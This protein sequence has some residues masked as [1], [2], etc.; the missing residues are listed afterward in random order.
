MVLPCATGELILQK[1]KMGFKQILVNVDQGNGES[2]AVIGED[3]IF[4]DDHHCLANSALVE[5]INQLIAAVN[6]YN[7]I[8]NQKPVKKGLFVG[9][10]DARFYLSVSSGDRLTLKANVLDVI[11]QVSFVQGIISRDGQKV[12]EFI[13]KLYDV[14]NAEEL[15]RLTNRGGLLA[16]KVGPSSEN[17]R[18]PF[19]PSSN[20][21]RSLMANIRNIQNG[22]EQI[23]FDMACPEDF[24][25]FDGHFPEHPLLPGVVLLEIGQLAMELLL[26][27][28]ICLQTIQKM[29]ISGVVLPTQ[30]ISC[31]VKIDEN[32]GSSFSFSA[33]LKGENG[34][35]ISR[36]NGT[37]V[38][39]ESNGKSKIG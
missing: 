34:K 39:E 32:T 10:Q 35:E 14:E 28:S 29:K 38:K 19:R 1:G 27:Q 33:I 12:A 3:H 20:L 13:T 6:G 22:G 18:L 4:L 15:N 7:N 30:L 11:A 9:V 24:I 5:Y 16:Y 31:T 17:D 26:K 37:G 2:T 23:S 36:Y 21:R 8:I 25:A